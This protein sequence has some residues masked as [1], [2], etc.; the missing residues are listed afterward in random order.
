MAP[1]HFSRSALPLHRDHTNISGTRNST[2]CNIAEQEDKM[3]EERFKTAITFASK[4]RLPLLLF[5]PDKIF[6][7]NV[8]WG[9]F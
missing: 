9:N 4:S 5:S 7:S 6:N 1:F 8:G 3:A 2:I